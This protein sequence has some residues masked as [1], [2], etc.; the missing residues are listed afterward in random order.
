MNPKD[1]AEFAQGGGDDAGADSRTGPTASPEPG[2]ADDSGPSIVDRLLTTDEPE[3]TSPQQLQAQNGMDE[4]IA[5][6]VY[7]VV[8]MA[9]QG[10]I[11]AVGYVLLGVFLQLQG[12]A[13]G[14]ANSGESEASEGDE[15]LMVADEGEL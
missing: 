12:A 15:M 13:A 6:A 14:D 3:S 10:G 8:M 4:G 11:P 1:A 9:G 5:N 7:G 2:P